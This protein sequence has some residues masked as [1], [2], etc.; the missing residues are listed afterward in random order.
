MNAVLRL[1]IGRGTVAAKAVRGHHLVWA[2]SAVFES[3]DDLREAIAQLAGEESLPVRLAGLRV[4]LETPLVQLRTLEHLPPVRDAALKALVAQQAGR[5]FRKNGKPLITDAAWMQR[6]RG[7]DAVAQAAAVEEPWIE[8]IAAGAR[9]AGLVLEEIHPTHDGVT[10]R[11]LSLVS[12]AELA[13]RR[14]MELLALRRLA[15][16]AGLLWMIAAGAFAI[17]VQ[18]AQGQV[19]RRLAALK[20]P[21]EA[22][23][24]ARRELAGATRMVETIEETQRNRGRMLLSLA[25]ITR[26][27]PDSSYLTSLTLD[28]HEG[29]ATGLSR[30][31]A[32]IVAALE[33][34]ATLAGPRLTGPVVREVSDGRELERFSLSFVRGLAP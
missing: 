16:V 1:R 8:A 6:E 24:A 30:Q 29:T 22:V 21:L 14:R 9:A 2:G 15:I 23:A 33:K 31:A 32:A 18:R 10:L 17:R 26:A 20:A 5:F 7:H 34:D 13:R 25:A 12:P 19:E 27:L 28:E 3:P 11:K 4:K